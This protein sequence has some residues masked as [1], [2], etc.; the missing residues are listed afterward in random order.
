MRS[1]AKSA[2]TSVSFSFGNVFAT[3]KHF[4]FA[5]FAARTP[6]TASSTIRHLSGVAPRRL[7]AAL[8]ICGEG[9]VSLTSSPEMITSNHSVFISAAAR[10]RAIF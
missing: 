9:F 3:A 1:P 8:K 4:A 10:V 7:I 6:E 2:P 5:A